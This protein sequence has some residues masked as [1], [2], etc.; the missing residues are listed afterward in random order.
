MID[1]E[2]LHHTIAERETG[3]P[4]PRGC[5]K[6]LA[7]I[8]DLA[9]EVANGQKT[10]ICV[11]THP[12]DLNYLFQMIYDVFREYELPVEFDKPRRRA[13]SGESL[14]IFSVEESEDKHK[15]FAFRSYTRGIDNFSVI[16]L[17]HWD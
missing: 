3:K 5:G 7:R 8:C 14:I 2:A 12:R 15:P 9:A 16:P 11:I 1:L 6:T 10:I 4:L 13:K 17:G